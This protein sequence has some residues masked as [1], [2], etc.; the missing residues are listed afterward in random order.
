VPSQAGHRFS[1]GFMSPFFNSNLRRL[2]HVVTSDAPLMAA[3]LAGAMSHVQP[4]NALT[5][6]AA[7]QDE[8]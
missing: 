6:G 4:T 1:F 2:N 8:V 7:P 5:A 3:N